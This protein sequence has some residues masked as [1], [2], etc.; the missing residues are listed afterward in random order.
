MQ[1][2]WSKIPLLVTRFSYKHCQTGFIRP[3]GYS[4]APCIIIKHFQFFLL[5]FVAFQADK[6]VLVF[7]KTRNQVEYAV[8]IW[9]W[10]CSELLHLCKKEWYS[11]VLAQSAQQLCSSN[12]TVLSLMDELLGQGYCL[13]VDNY[14]SFP[15]LADLLVRQ[16]TMLMAQ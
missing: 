9:K 3:G 16:K 4:A 1:Q 11:N 12:Q 2:Y 10:I 13:N 8:S 6:T 5:C 7:F 15:E 14:H